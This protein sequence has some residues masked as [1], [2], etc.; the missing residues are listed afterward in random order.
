MAQVTFVSTDPKQPN[1]FFFNPLLFKTFELISLRIL[2]SCLLLM[3]C[4]LTLNFDQKLDT[5][6]HGHQTF[7]HANQKIAARIAI[8]AGQL[9]GV[10]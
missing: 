1:T 5:L 10:T 3:I 6:L 2:D 4:F 7:P 9:L 8:F